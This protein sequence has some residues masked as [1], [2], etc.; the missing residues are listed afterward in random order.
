METR[1]RFTPFV[2]S[3]L[4]TSGE[5]IAGVRVGGCFLPVCRVSDRPDF[6]SLFLPSCIAQIPVCG[7]YCL[8]VFEL[9]QKREI[10]C[11]VQKVQGSL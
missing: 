2:R 1:V 6:R 10:F 3:F 9:K 5:G 8:Q 11:R 4:S 7:I